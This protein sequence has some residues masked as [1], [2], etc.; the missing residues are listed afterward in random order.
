MRIRMQVLHICE[1]FELLN[2]RMNNISI[3]HVDTFKLSFIFYPVTFPFV[4]STLTDV[5]VDKPL[6][7]IA[8]TMYINWGLFV[9]LNLMV[10]S[11]A[12]GAVEFNIPSSVVSQAW[13]WY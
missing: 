2:A 11:S 7:S 13:Q 8:Y 1:E 3:K 10:L 5:A 6:Y 4:T 12:N 9:F